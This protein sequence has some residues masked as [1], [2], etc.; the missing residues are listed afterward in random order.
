MRDILDALETIHTNK[1][2]PM[3]VKKELNKKPAVMKALSLEDEHVDEVLSGKG[4]AN[5]R[6]MIS[7]FERMAE[8]MNLSQEAMDAVAMG[9]DQIMADV[10]E[11]EG[12]SENKTPGDSHYNKE[13][14]KE[15]AKKDGKDPERLTHGELMS[16]I[17]KAEKMDE[18]KFDGYKIHRLG[19]LQKKVDEVAK[20]IRLLG[21]TD[22]IEYATGAG[23]LT[24]QI[25]TM[26]KAVMMLQDV[27]ERANSIVPDPM[28][29]KTESQVDE[30]ESQV[31]EGGFKQAQIEI[32]DWA[33]KYN[34]FKGTNA[35]PLAHGYLQ[36]M[37]NT[38]IMSDAYEEN[39]VEA[40]N[41]MK[42]YGA[43]SNDAEWAE[44]DHEDFTDNKSGVSPITAGM[45]ST[46]GKILGKYGLEDDD[47][48]DALG[49]FESKGITTGTGK[50]D[51]DK[52]LDKLYGAK[53]GIKR[54]DEIINSEENKMENNQKDTVEVAVED[55]ARILDLAG[56]GKETIKAEAEMDAHSADMEKHIP[57]ISKM[58]DELMDKGMEPEDA[59]DKA[60]DKYGFDPDDVSE[61]MDKKNEATE[62]AT[63]EAPNE[64][65]LDE[66]SN[67]PDE[68]YSDADTQ[69]NKLSGGI[70][71]PKK[72]FKK[73]YPGDNPL[74]VDLEQK[75]AKMLS[76]M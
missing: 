34:K 28:H 39:E 21:K 26:N 13:K 36:A 75:L 51:L 12:V 14:A 11:I 4:R 60:C 54:K 53:K 45:F 6:K 56:L 48:N 1:K 52:S 47:V 50:K 7:D 41:K 27:I 55:L 23:D 29:G 72:Q 61:Y 71:G 65:E 74:A 32:Q 19:E 16:Y 70:N 73:E 58:R 35:D 15:L 59:F 31:D 42:G 25:T 24:D 40:F 43:D 5:L 46:I 63:T 64:V 37:L 69:L 20:D 18:D 22:S 3:D 57:M 8:E 62:E 30:T 9:L 44:G 38:G 2:K 67:S 33:E 17:E 49:Y 76:D 68:H 66:Y 10:Q